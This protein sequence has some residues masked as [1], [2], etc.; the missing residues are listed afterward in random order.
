MLTQRQNNDAGIRDEW[1]PDREVWQFVF[2]CLEKRFNVDAA[3][4]DDRWI[5]LGIIG[6]LM[7]VEVTGWWVIEN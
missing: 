7:W 5:P 4:M 1:L 6:T 2:D 3:R